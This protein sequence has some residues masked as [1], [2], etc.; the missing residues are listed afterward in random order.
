MNKKWDIF[1]SYASEDKEMVQKLYLLLQKQDIQVWLDQE[2][3]KVGDSITKKINEGLLNSNYFIPFISPSY[4]DKKWTQL[5]LNAVIGLENSEDKNILP[6]WHNISYGVLIK[7]NPLIADKYALKT[8]DGI[9]TISKA[10]INHIKVKSASN[11][12]LT[13]LL[14]Y[15][16]D[17]SFKDLLIAMNYNVLWAN[18]R[19]D[20]IK[21]AMNNDFDIALEWQHGPDDFPIKDILNFINK[22]LPVLLCLNWNNTV[23]ENYKT[24]GYAD[25]LNV[26]WS[27]NEFNL[28][29]NKYINNKKNT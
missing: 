20:L 17:R 13:I 23:I 19:N 1:I 29:I 16:L 27:L 15:Y 11:S 14:P 5:E 24:K 7:K 2:E 6:V 26:P 28:K 12:Q 4:L 22:D 10:I 21:L 3:L 8:E 9:E 25:Y 18:N